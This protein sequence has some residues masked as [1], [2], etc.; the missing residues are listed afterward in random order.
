MNYLVV[1]IDVIDA[2]PEFNGLGGGH[3]AGVDGNEGAGRVHEFLGSFYENLEH[4]KV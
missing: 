2:L 1:G 3:E 4:E